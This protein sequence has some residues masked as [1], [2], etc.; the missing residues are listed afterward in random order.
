MT[1]ENVTAVSCSTAHYD[2]LQTL[3]AVHSI[4]VFQSRK[5]EPRNH[6]DTRAC[7]ARKR[8]DAPFTTD[9]EAVFVIRHVRNK[10]GVDQLMPRFWQISTLA[11]LAVVAAACS[12]S[13]ISPAVSSNADISTHKLSDST[14]AHHGRKPRT[15]GYG[16]IY[17]IV[18][19]FSTPNPIYPSGPF[20]IGS[21]GTLF[22]TVSANTV[23]TCGD[24]YCGAVVKYIPSTSTYSTVHFFTGGSGGAQP[25]EGVVGDGGGNLYG[26][27]Y[28]DGD[29]TCKCGIVFSVNYTGG[30]FT[31]LHRFSGGTDGANPNGLIR[32]SD[33]NLYGMAEYG[34]NTTCEVGTG[35]GTIF[36]ITPSGAFT[37]LHSF[38]DGM[39]GHTPAGNLVQDSNGVLYGTTAF[40]GTKCDGSIS[41][42]VVF[43]MNTDGTNYTVIYRFQG[44]T[45]DGETP[46]SELTLDSNGNL[47]G[48]TWA[49]GF[50]TCAGDGVHFP[51]GCGTAFK[52][53]KSGSTYTESVL[54]K[55]SAN[56]AN[57]PRYPSGLL[58]QGSL[59]YGTTQSGGSCSAATG[60]CGEIFDL[61]LSGPES[62]VHQFAGCTTDG[63]EG[64][65][66]LVYSTR[67]RLTWRQ[68]IKLGLISPKTPPP[69]HAGNLGIGTALTASSTVTFYGATTTGGVGSSS[70]GYGEGYGTFFSFNA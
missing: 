63:E 16:V 33:G 47:Y 28:G 68:A 13:G 10:R 38:A 32:G 14:A 23:T 1:R 70:C 29:S 9:G 15:S 19:N 25:Q 20:W 22:G 60:G 12:N 35:C 51:A 2:A 6:T 67:H 48:T 42:G 50:A 40:G 41:C 18:P 7:L 69:P 55:F 4:G 24:Y 43:S 36:K 31:V 59:L 27:T 30:S 17:S 37:L 54:H 34:G 66:S 61:T 56:S 3:Q 65:G 52:L 53:A 49:G 44:G 8:V 62:S 26:T 64:A 45:T 58:L 5:R 21:T 57:A 39:N 11:V 46:E